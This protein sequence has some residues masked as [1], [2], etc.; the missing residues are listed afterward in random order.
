MAMHRRARKWLTICTILGAAVLSIV[1]AS[2]AADEPPKRP[3]IPIDPSVSQRSVDRAEAAR[4]ERGTA[5]ARERRER[6]RSA[7]RGLG[8]DEAIALARAK[9]PGLASR[10]LGM[11]LG[12]E[13]DQ[14]LVRFLGAGSAIVDMGTHNAIASS[15]APMAVQDADG[16]W[17]A[18][19]LDFVASGAG[20]AVQQPAVAA[21]APALAGQV[22]KVGGAGVGIVPL[23]GAATSPGELVDGR[24]FWPS[25]AT[26]TDVLALPVPEGLEVAYFLR[27]P[28]A[29]EDVTL[30][31]SLPEGAAAQRGLDPLE[32]VRV[33]KDGVDLAHITAPVAVDAGGRSLDVKYAVRD[34]DLVMH[35]DHHGADV[36][37][38]I[39]IDPIVNGVST[40]EL[41]QEWQNFGHGFDGW[42]TNVVFQDG[43]AQPWRFSAGDVGA[44][45][46][47]N[48]WRDAGYYFPW[49]RG[50]W[51]RQAPGNS[52]IVAV[53]VRSIQWWLS[54]SCIW[55]GI[56][57]Y[58]GGSYP[59]LNHYEDCRGD[60]FTVN[61]GFFYG[62]GPMYTPLPGV[63]DTHYVALVNHESTYPEGNR[64][65]H[66]THWGNVEMF[67]SDSVGPVVSTPSVPTNWVNPDRVNINFT[68]SA[69]DAGVGLSK[70]GID[71]SWAAG[72]YDFGGSN[73]C[74][75]NYFDVCPGSDTQTV[76]MKS[77]PD[78][79]HTVRTRAEDLLS[80][81]DA[82]NRAPVSSFA[83]VRADRV[84]PATTVGG[85]SIVDSDPHI[86]VGT[87]RHAVDVAGTDTPASGANGS[88]GARTTTVSI[89]SQKAQ[90][91][92]RF[93]SASGCA[94]NCSILGRYTFDGTVNTAA[95]GRDSF[96]DS[97]GRTLQ[98]HPAEAGGPWTKHA[99][100]LNDAVI[101][102]AGRARR[103]DI[104]ENTTLMT[105]TSPTADYE[106]AADL[107]VP[108][109]DQK[110]GEAG[111]VIRFDNASGQGYF[112]VYSSM[113]RQWAIKRRNT[114]GTYTQL[115]AAA[116][117]LTAGAT[118][119][120]LLRVRGSW[121]GFFVGDQLV[122]DAIDTTIAGA[123]RFGVYWWSEP[124]GGASYPSDGSTPQLDNFISYGTGHPEGVYTFDFTTTD[125]AG[126]ST[127]KPLPVVV[128]RTAPTQD[129]AFGTLA[130]V[131]AVDDDVHDVSVT[132]RDPGTWPNVAGMGRFEL[133]VDGTVVDT[134]SPPAP[135]KDYTATMEVDATA[136]GGLAQGWH[137][138]VV[139]S[140]DDAIRQPQGTGNPSTNPE[141]IPFIVDRSSP[142]MTTSGA[143]K[144]ND[145][146]SVPRGL[147]SVDISATDASTDGTARAG[148]GTIEVFVDG[149][150]EYRQNQDC[151]NGSCSMSRT[152]TFD[153]RSHSGGEHE[154][155]VVASDR[156]GNED[157]EI[158]V[159]T[160]PCCTQ[161]TQTW[162]TVV[163]QDVRFGDVNADGIDD[164]V[165][166]DRATGAIE[167]GLSGGS[168]FDGRTVWGNT[169]IPSS[170][171][172]FEL[173]DPNG[174]ERDDVIVVAPT[175]D[176]NRVE[177]RVLLSDGQR[178]ADPKRWGTWPRDYDLKV[179]DLAGDDYEDL[180]GR[181]ATDGAVIGAHSDGD[182]FDPEDALASTS[183]ND[184][185]LF[186][187]VDGDDA[188]D[189]VSVTSTNRLLVSL[190][191][192]SFFGPSVDWGAIPA[193]SDVALGDVNGDG[194]TDAVAR[195]RDTGAVQYA[196]GGETAFAVS[197][198]LGNWAAA[199][200]LEL[201]DVTGDD[202][203]DLV[204]VRASIPGSVDVGA[205]TAP[206]P[207]APPEDALVVDDLPDE[208]E[209]SPRSGTFQTRQAG[210]APAV[211]AL[212]AEQDVQLVFRQGLNGV[213]ARFAFD[214]AKGDANERA[215]AE[216]QITVILD[217]LRE[218]GV[219][220][221]RVDLWWGMVQNVKRNAAGEPTFD[222]ER[223]VQSVQFIRD[224]GFD[225]ELTLTGVANPGSSLE[226]DQCHM[227]LGNNLDDM[228][229][230]PA[231]QKS[232]GC[233]GPH[234]ATG[235][236]P[237]S[238]TARQAAFDDWAVFVREAV[239]RFSNL[240]PRTLPDGTS[241]PRSVTK[242][243]LWNEP[244]Y[245]GGTQ[246]LAQEGRKRTRPANMAATYRTLYQRGY[247]A[248]KGANAN[249]IV[250]FGELA[251]A[252]SNYWS[253]NANGNL[254]PD[255]QISPIEWIRQVAPAGQTLNTDG[256][257]YHPYQHDTP[258]W[259]PGKKKHL[260]MGR[261]P[262]LY[263]DLIALRRASRLVV[264]M[265][266]GQA[267][268]TPP[269]YLTEFGYLNTL[270][271]FNQPTPADAEERNKQRAERKL[272]YRRWHTESER[273]RWFYGGRS[274][275]GRAQY[276]ALETARFL[277]ARMMV[278]YG[279]IES[280]P[281]NN[282][283]RGDRAPTQDYGLMGGG[284]DGDGQASDDYGSPLG[285]VEGNRLY[286]K[287]PND[288]RSSWFKQPRR[289][290]CHIRYWATKQPGKPY[291][292]PNAPCKNTRGLLP[293]Y[294][295][296]R[297]P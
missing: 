20:F 249:A 162:D 45:R 279:V 142:V 216:A 122:T 63:A 65:F 259:L 3:T 237:A 181:R 141:T 240:A 200:P 232:L 78:G 190:S 68:G 59:W 166:R 73:N 151:P 136:A 242:F 134:A 183:P 115:S 98:T 217:R 135:A 43:R 32:G 198:A 36:E 290:F 246:F 291:A 54:K 146:Q 278:F 42:N 101:T 113:D 81:T 187:D 93:V 80:G 287:D 50:D 235:A 92:S 8:R 202:R 1:A 201:A 55:I 66:M 38:P 82:V 61:N 243:A 268:R 125:G 118:Y 47:L 250:L 58:S 221:I 25:A 223:Y 138:A 24:I 16:H 254:K 11:A 199:V 4:R 14:R 87:G 130:E 296:L 62:V 76:N 207:P 114:D 285:E 283:P 222:F 253:P 155:E 75:G 289:V 264:P 248:A 57:R 13:G 148:M 224:A 282:P 116:A 86:A 131:R 70:Q 269:L 213:S 180:V 157:S 21:R 260:G 27:S 271:P 119:R 133:S 111:L 15:S 227:N 197:S 233:S 238:G 149:D 167:V 35:V 160:T 225:V 255:R 121:I 156:A 203:A 208:R 33:A 37:Y 293:T 234:R 163:A 46:G 105:A 28:E 286:G 263:N 204:G 292:T 49:E 100:S 196:S 288:R 173:G 103:S 218:Q 23:L 102:A 265:P 83:A 9:H 275:R 161:T 153:T 106:S 220:M 132:G 193:N 274:R 117:N 99:S 229:G 186:D 258:P 143:L 192:A 169:G 273:A 277:H 236:I 164:L 89:T 188:V 108:A 171:L 17:R 276:G 185:V 44:G 144:D 127:S 79:E 140:A 72:T 29:A 257:A 74:T 178:F 64:G 85:A 40:V 39:A 41:E 110:Q 294:R 26:D 195:A 10:R 95:Y 184:R 145:G 231:D 18:V 228:M 211:P 129:P 139:R 230:Q 154:I 262:S 179:R 97:S 56:S 245:T 247:S 7:H 267:P 150:S 109:L 172:T 214:D 137:T 30:G 168:D 112:G 239:K 165:T 34:G 241:T 96:T 124:K 244:N 104:G 67:Y 206:P 88:S 2:V 94:R 126:N 123:G 31:L 280:P 194:L 12:L 189:M 252:Q 256:V 191:Q 209:L 266:A 60:A 270:P 22:A 51:V 251:S 261:L 152:Y 91:E 107:Y 19:D 147:Y 48:I 176:P 272:R 212:A 77:V 84:S 158:Y 205:V 215:K 170:L 297:H 210:T 159:I 174:D 71:A 281:A 182:L 53:N 5:K 6:S 219:S 69:T 295:P 90:R 128:D 175:T 226:A 52:F 284:W 120:L 177:V